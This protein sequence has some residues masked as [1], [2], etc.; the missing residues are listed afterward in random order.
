LAR[1]VLLTYFLLR[2]VKLAFLYSTC[3]LVMEMGVKVGQGDRASSLARWEKRPTNGEKLLRVKGSG[4]ETYSRIPKIRELG[5]SREAIKSAVVF[6]LFSFS[7]LYFAFRFSLF[8]FHFFAFPF[9]FWPF[10][11]TTV[12]IGLFQPQQQQKAKLEKVNLLFFLGNLASDYDANRNSCLLFPSALLFGFGVKAPFFGL[13]N[14]SPSR[15]LKGGR[16]RSGKGLGRRM[17]VV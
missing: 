11:K 16:R 10:F 14:L 6:Q 3:D 17:G 9:F 7:L 15:F 8:A 4:R 12:A 5:S 13:S 1:F 2:F